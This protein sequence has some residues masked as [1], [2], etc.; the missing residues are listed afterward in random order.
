LE[1][2]DPKL[3]AP[4]E[5]GG[6]PLLTLALIASAAIALVSLLLAALS[7]GPYLGVASLN[8]WVALFAVASFAALFAIPFATEHLL[9]AAHPER[10][11]RW[12]RAMLIW[13]G[14]ATATLALGLALIVAAGFDPGGSLADAAGLLLTIEAGMVVATLV[15]WVL[16]D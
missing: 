10:D 13:G 8:G 16:S 2:T 7:G 11:E 5:E 1:R 9:R 4:R 12:E 6:R 14:V 15:F 3:D